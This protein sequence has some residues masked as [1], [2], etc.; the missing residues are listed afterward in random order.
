MSSREN[1]FI[2]DERSQ[3]EEENDV[4]H[5]SCA[6]LNSFLMNNLHTP[7]MTTTDLYTWRK[8]TSLDYWMTILSSQPI[9]KGYVTEM[10]VIPV[11]GN[12]VMIGC[13]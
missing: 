1:S 6:A 2:D 5:S 12:A 9:K 7:Y 11:K 4:S 8:T 13:G 10:T 3:K